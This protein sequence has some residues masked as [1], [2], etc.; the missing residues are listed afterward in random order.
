MTHLE[1]NLKIE[2]KYGQNHGY[3]PV[4]A[5]IVRPSKKQVHDHNHCRT[6]QKNYPITLVGERRNFCFA[7]IRRPVVG[8]PTNY[9]LSVH[10]TPTQHCKKINPRHS[11]KRDVED[12]VPYI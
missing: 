8:R 2:Y 12:A 3:T 11:P 9:T 4:G 5:N 10:G 6:E 1:R 7:E